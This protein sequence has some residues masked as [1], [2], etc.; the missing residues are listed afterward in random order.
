MRIHQ[1]WS[2][3]ALFLGAACLAAGIYAAAQSTASQSEKL[4]RRA[5]GADAVQAFD[6]SLKFVSQDA[7]PKPVND[8]QHEIVI[9]MTGPDPGD[10]SSVQYRVYDNPADAAAHANPN[11][12]QQKAER[13]A[14]D[15]PQ[16][17]FHSYHSNLT[18]SALASD[19]PQP[20]HC[21]SSDQKPAWSRCYYY[22]GGQSDIVVVGTT[23]STKANEAILI[24]AMG[25]Q[26]LGKA[27]PE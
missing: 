23:S 9:S 6:S 24:T 2:A 15:S 5:L 14:F 3:G 17:Q 22:A 13:D 21:R 25:A 7:L 1:S 27:K 4:A 16:G 26:S 8:A 19:V 11:A 18:G 10:K 20:F 12:A